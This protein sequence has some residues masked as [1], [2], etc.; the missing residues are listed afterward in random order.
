VREEARL[1]DVSMIVLTAIARWFGEADLS[2]MHVDSFLERPVRATELVAR[3]REMLGAGCGS[4]WRSV[5][6]SR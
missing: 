6:R 5:R 3:V 1:A 4:R 2:A